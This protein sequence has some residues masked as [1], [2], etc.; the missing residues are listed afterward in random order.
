[1][2]EG[3]VE[4]RWL[5]FRM[6]RRVRFHTGRLFSELGVQVEVDLKTEDPD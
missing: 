1:M 5:I 6:N 2:S 3:I 4:M